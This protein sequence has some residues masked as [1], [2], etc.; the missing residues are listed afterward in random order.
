ME[1]FLPVLRG[2]AL[3]FGLTDEQILSSL[4]CIGATCAAKP[5]DAYI[6]CAGESVGKM[7]L[8]LSGSALVIQED[9]WGHRSIIQ[10]LTTGDTFAEPFA[11]AGSEQLNVSV[12]AGGDCRLMWLD[13]GRILTIC[14]SACEHHNRIVRNLVSVLAR[15]LLRFNEKITHTSRRTT[16]EK[17]LS[18]LSAEAMRQG[19]LCFSIAFDRQQLADYL[20]VERSAMSA[21]LSR[22]QRDGI[23][24]YEKNRFVLHADPEKLPG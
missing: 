3:F 11:A 12:V 20:C 24:H 23:L 6:L 15:K 9:V 14:P 16:R 5:K 13:V 10:Q 19:S 2:T 8:L 7:G 1:E 4:A 22:M 17:L 21:E 18:Y